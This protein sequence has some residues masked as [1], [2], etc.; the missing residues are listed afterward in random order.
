MN[1]TQEHVQEEFNVGDLVTI[2]GLPG[3]YKL[4]V[5]EFHPWVCTCIQ[6]NRASKCY[7]H[8]NVRTSLLRKLL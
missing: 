6:V 1:Y 3:N 2:K 5:H 4:L 7:E 8:I